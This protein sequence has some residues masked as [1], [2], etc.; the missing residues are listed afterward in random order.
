M[1]LAVF[2]SV[3]VSGLAAVAF[4]LAGCKHN[5]NP[6]PGAVGR[7]F[8]RA[9]ARRKIALSLSPMCW[10]RRRQSVLIGLATFRQS[11]YRRAA[12]SVKIAQP[13]DGS[14]PLRVV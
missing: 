2:G 12:A 9:Q 10:D 3:V 6:R 5:K 7:R 14:V 1:L 11:V 8:R 13:D 4:G